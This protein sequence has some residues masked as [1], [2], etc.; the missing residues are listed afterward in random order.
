MTILYNEN[1]DADDYTPL[2]KPQGDNDT[3]RGSYRANHG[4]GTED[5]EA[6]LILQACHALN[7]LHIRYDEIGWVAESTHAFPAAIAGVEVTPK[8]F[9]FA[10]CPKNSRI[11]IDMT[12]GTD[13]QVQIDIETDQ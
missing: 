10:N 2:L 11:M 12:G 1:V 6:T 4:A 5:L 8:E 3:I 13:G 9:N 7:P